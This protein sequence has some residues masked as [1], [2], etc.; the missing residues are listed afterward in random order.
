MRL[1]TEYIDRKL[2]KSAI[3]YEEINAREQYLLQK[4]SST[5]NNYQDKKMLRNE[6][7]VCLRGSLASK[8]CSLYSDIDLVILTFNNIDINALKNRLYNDFEREL[9]ILTYRFSNLNNYC[10]SFLFISSIH[11]MIYF[12]GNL[13]IYKIF[14]HRLEG[15]LKSLSRIELIDLYRNDIFSRNSKFQH[16]IKIGSF[17]LIKFDLVNL[18][19]T[20]GLLTKQEK[21]KY[22][23][24]EVV[25]IFTKRYIQQIT[26]SPL[27]NTFILERKPF[28]YIKNKYYL[29]WF[30]LF[31]IIKPLFILSF[32]K[33]IKYY[34]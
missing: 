11:N 30:L 21:D 24:Y 28:S 32:N 29:V 17:S 10:E 23:L 25:L 27:E 8:Q 31:T 13:Q 20:L 33:T 26:N 1:I 34:G 6:I 12:H 2:L 22:K 3:N 7:C 4:L 5:L 9:S 16:S 18:L 19:I 14:K 15:I